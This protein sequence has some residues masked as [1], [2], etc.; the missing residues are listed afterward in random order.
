MKIRFLGRI[1]VLFIGFLY[2]RPSEAAISVVKHGV[3]PGRDGALRLGK[4]N[5]HVVAVHTDVHGLLALAVAEFCRAI[6]PTA[7]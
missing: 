5:A 4:V 3:L 2:D 6:E 1:T 7:L